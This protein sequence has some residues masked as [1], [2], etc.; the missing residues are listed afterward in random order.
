MQACRSRWAW[1]KRNKPCCKTVCAAGIVLEADGKLMDGR[2]V[3]IA[4]LLAPKNSVRHHAAHRDGLLDAARLP[5]RYLPSGH[6]HAKPRVAGVLL[7]QAR[8]YVVNYMM[9]VAEQTREIMAE[10]GFATIDEMV[11]QVECLRQTHDA[12]S[13]K[14]TWSIFRRC[15]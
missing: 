9:M 3:A 11:G 4:C 5:A 12:R 14:A 13:W 10:L 15:S 6:R 7:R 1:P 2:D 8:N